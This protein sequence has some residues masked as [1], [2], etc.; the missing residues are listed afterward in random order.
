MNLFFI[1]PVWASMVLWYKSLD[2]FYYIR[3][4]ILHLTMETQAWYQRAQIL[5][6]TQFIASVALLTNL[7]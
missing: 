3:E 5:A 2:E 7:K 6:V 4:S 1:D